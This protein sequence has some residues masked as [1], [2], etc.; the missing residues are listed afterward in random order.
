MSEK[1]KVMADEN[2]IERIVERLYRADGTWGD[3]EIEYDA[4]S[5]S[6]HGYET[7][8]RYDFGRDEFP[9]IS[10]FSATRQDV[11]AFYLDVDLN[12][13]NVNYFFTETIMGA[14]DL[15]ARWVPLVN[16]REQVDLMP[17][18]ERAFR[19]WHGHDTNAVCREC[20]PLEHERRIKADQE[21]QRRRESKKLL[22]EE[23]PDHAA[24]TQ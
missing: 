15:A 22:N 8:S 4:N 14:F 6:P 1:E 24:Q 3:V 21:Y 10:I 19:A 17:I 9:R 7:F 23:N 13:S 11:P 16:S 18:I 5:C 12:S 20:D 2:K